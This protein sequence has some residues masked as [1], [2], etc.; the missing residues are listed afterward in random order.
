MRYY[1]IYAR[2]HSGYPELVGIAGTEGWA[3]LLADA[4]ACHADTAWIAVVEHPVGGVT[5][6]N[7]LSIPAV[8]T[9]AVR[10]EEGSRP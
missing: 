7:L 1:R 5:S 3:W 9:L 4:A 2:Q 6:D 10:R 8:R